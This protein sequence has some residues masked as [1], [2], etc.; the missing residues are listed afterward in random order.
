MV[1]FF[2]TM[3]IQFVYFD[4]GGVLLN[5]E[6]ALVKIA[7]EHAKSEK[8]VMDVF[9][10]YDA[11]FCRGL[12]DIETMERTLTKELNLNDMKD[13]NFHEFVITRFEKIEKM[14][15]LLYEVKKS[16]K[17]GLLT[18]LHKGSFDKIVNKKF[19]PDVE[20]D[21][22]VKSYEVGFI[23]PEKEI[24]QIAQE[25]SGFVGNEI[26]FIDD[27]AQNI[28]AAQALG[29]HGVIFDE[30]KADESIRKINKLLKR[31]V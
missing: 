25:K 14:H 8:E 9:A 10:K 12:V 20:Y 31:V 21:A 13:F 22:V 28:A 26:L 4:I 3:N 11:D 17:V 5:W 24:Y 15:T 16:Y 2:P 7:K 1:Y 27:L 18:N 19:I 30:K 6:K 23:K 29:W